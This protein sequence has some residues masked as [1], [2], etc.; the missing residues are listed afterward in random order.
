[1]SV[2]APVSLH[3]LEITPEEIQAGFALTEHAT[4]IRAAVIHLAGGLR[5]VKARRDDGA[6]MYVVC[7]EDLS[8]L[9]TPA[10]TLR[11]LLSRFGIRRS[12]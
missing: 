5:A 2:W 1:M 4:G 7:S 10:A 6:V 3:V 11:E 9:Y 12:G 8:P